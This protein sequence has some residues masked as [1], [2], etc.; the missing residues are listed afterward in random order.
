[1]LSVVACGGTD[2]LA[3]CVSVRL[4]E[5][6]LSPLMSMMVMEELGFY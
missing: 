2:L 3:F 6:V 4:P 1:M 5:T